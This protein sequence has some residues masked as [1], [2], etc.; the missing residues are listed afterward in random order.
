[1]TTEK[2]VLQNVIRHWCP[3]LT[4]AFKT[5]RSVKHVC[6]HCEGV[7]EVLEAQ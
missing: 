3:A 2:A 4:A 5:T 6:G 1:M 7:R